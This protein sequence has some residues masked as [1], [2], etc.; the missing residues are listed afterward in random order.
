M[1]FSGS[2]CSLLFHSTL[3]LV[4]FSE[5]VLQSWPNFLSEVSGGEHNTQAEGTVKS[6]FPSLSWWVQDWSDQ[7]ESDVLMWLSAPTVAKQGDAAW[8][9]LAAMFLTKWKGHVNC[10]NRAAIRMKQRA[11]MER[12]LTELK[13]LVAIISEAAYFYSLYG[14]YMFLFYPTWFALLVSEISNQVFW[15][16]SNIYSFFYERERPVFVEGLLCVVLYIV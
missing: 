6:C 13:S 7:L 11:K 2:V 12:G 1:T 16:I 3:W 4:V 5:W 14:Q 15:L 9:L 8:D 10:M